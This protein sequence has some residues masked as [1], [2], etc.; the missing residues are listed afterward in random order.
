MNIITA[1]ASVAMPKAVA[2]PATAG[3]RRQMALGTK[4][5]AAKAG[6]LLNAVEIRHSGL[7]FR[8]QQ[9]FPVENLYPCLWHVRLSLLRRLA[10]GECQ[11]PEASGSSYNDTHSGHPSFLQLPKREFLNSSSSTPSA[12][13]RISSAVA[14]TRTSELG[15]MFNRRFALRLASCSFCQY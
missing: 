6:L 15:L 7:L 4:G 5:S 13:S 3:N 1:M 10:C 9:P 2:E 8:G 14:L 11:H 12:V